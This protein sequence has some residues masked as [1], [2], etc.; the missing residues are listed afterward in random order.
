MHDAVTAELIDDDVDRLVATFLPEID[1]D[2]RRNDIR[3][4]LTQVIQRSSEFV[5][6]DDQ[7]MQMNVL[8]GRD[9]LFIRFAGDL[10][11][12]WLP[13]GPAKDIP[14]ALEPELLRVQT[15]LV[16]TTLLRSLLEE[17]HLH[18]D[19]G[20]LRGDDPEER[21]D[22]FVERTRTRAGLAALRTAHP[23]AFAT[24]RLR[25]D[26]AAAVTMEVLD[27]IAADRALIAAT[28]P[29]VSEDAP[30]ERVG[31]GSGDPHRDGRSVALVRFADGGR[32]VHRPRD[33]RV[34]VAW[35]GFLQDLARL[36]VADLRTIAT[37][38]CGDHG[39]AEYVTADDEASPG[40]AYLDGVG[41]LTAVLHL[42]RGTDIH[43]ENLL[44]SGGL[45][46]VVDTETV[47]SPRPVAAPSYDDGAG[48]RIARDEVLDSVLGIGILPN[49]VRAPGGDLAL[50]VGAV[51]YAPGQVSPFRALG[52]A[53]A[54]RDDMHTV[55]TQVPTTM[56]SANPVLTASDD[57][58]TARDRIA[59]AFRATAERVLENRTEVVQAV[60]SRFQDVVLR[61]VHAPTMFYAQL[62][63]MATHPDM[64]DDRAARTAVLYRV[65]LRE[66][67]TARS[68][69]DLEL[70][71]LLAGDVPY[72]WCRADERAVHNDRAGSVDDFFVEPA[73][74]TAVRRIEELSPAAVDRQLR[75]LDL[76]FVNRLDVGGEPTVLARPRSDGQ[77]SD[78]A[79]G[80][81]D[82]LSTAADSVVAG[83][84]DAVVRDC[85]R[86]TDPIHPATWVG[87]QVTTSEQSQWLPGTLGYD[88]YGGSTGVALF[89]AGA[90]ASLGDERWAEVAEAVFRPVEAQLVEGRI[91][92]LDVSAGGMTGIGGT[93]WALTTS[94]HLLRAAGMLDGER[95]D[96]ERDRLLLGVLGDAARSDASPD[97]T[98]GLAGTLAAGLA[99][100]AAL[101]STADPR[102]VDMIAA[103]MTE[104][105]RRRRAA[106]DPVYTGYAHGLAG[107][108]PPLLRWADT[109][110][111]A[112]AA[113]TA[114]GLLDEL[115]AARLDDG[116]WPR[117]VGGAADQRSY[118]W[119]HGAPGILLGLLD[120][121]RLRPGAVP[122][123]VLADLAAIS[124]H[125]AIGHNATLCHGD[126]GTLDVLAEAA[127]ELGDE[128]LARFVDDAT[129]RLVREQFADGS[130]R[131]D[132]KYDATDSLM[133]GSAGTGWSLLRHTRPGRFPSVL[134]FR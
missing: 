108:V 114:T 68:L 93:V 69:A 40:P 78:D 17:L 37:L 85:R 98:S 102:P 70:A 87:P 66:G 94:R 11:S 120:V 126:L 88:L 29:G 86:S 79:A 2:D 14:Q 89:L 34:D 57:S 48:S 107:M 56:P 26:R 121:R 117:L 74:E 19:A 71:D 110:G 50:D 111:D 18:R 118:A 77:S 31:L 30:V 123:T 22:D 95:A 81:R 46:V 92:A 100:E 43:H 112:R 101:G 8:N 76:A 47:L 131:R 116:D 109:R 73:V 124:R 60:R 63:R 27:H 80:L 20:L 54:G 96:P 115:L 32:V 83:I 106:E 99:L 128:E 72:F 45:P 42:L 44:T 38:D 33:V 24:A 62:L 39:Y 130:R 21:F 28:I 113:T 75:L 53:S 12:A 41:Q 51:G 58:R 133:V 103:A 67:G 127:A 59:A 90:A 52:V 97:F 4:R 15:D 55:L 82:S 122:E 3:D 13:L 105:L 64:L 35:N 6:P 84:A 23:G 10:A 61:Y 49:L 16:A 132:S 134:A 9:P 1:D 91:D 104:A 129:A 25:A 65:S 5:V 7:P 125:E 36:G 119:C